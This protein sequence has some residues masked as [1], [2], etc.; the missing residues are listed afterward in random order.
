MFL[1]LLRRILKPWRPKWTSKIRVARGQGVQAPPPPPG[2]W[3]VLIGVKK[4]SPMLR[5][6]VLVQYLE[7]SS[8]GSGVESEV[9]TAQPERGPK[10]LI[11]TR[12]HHGG[13][14]SLFVALFWASGI[15]SR[16]TRSTFGWRWRVCV[17]IAATSL[18][19]ILSRFSRPRSS[20]LRK[21]S[22]RLVGGPLLRVNGIV[23]RPSGEKSVCTGG[24]SWSVRWSLGMTWLRERRSVVRYRPSKE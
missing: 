2:A 21:A 11:G 14:G 16:P 24:E 17:S 18:P 22:E 20:S 3:L 8:G 13:L 9:S 12:M 6:A 19:T 10:T 23:N 1:C 5:R 7:R 15:F 4:V